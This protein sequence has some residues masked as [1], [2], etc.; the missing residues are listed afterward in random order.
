MERSEVA[1]LFALLRTA[2]FGGTLTTE[3]RAAYSP[4]RIS[5]LVPLAEAHDV[6]HL[7]ALGL[8]RA[9]FAESRE[10]EGEIFRAVLRCETQSH[11]L[12]TI[13][14]A[15]E[16]AHI[17]FVPLKGA[18]LRRHYP[19][20]WMRTSCDIDVLVHE[21]ELS[22]AIEQLEARGYRCEGRNY[23][24]VDLYAPSGVHV[25]LHF[26]IRENTPSLDGV[27]DDAWRYA[28]PVTEGGARCEF[29][30]EFF[31][32]HLYAHMAYHFLGGG[33]GLRSLLDILVL[34]REM[35]L[36]RADAAELLERAG[37]SRFASELS[38]LAARCFDPAEHEFFSDAVLQYIL[39]GGAYGSGENHIAVCKSERDSTALYA[40]KRLFLPYRSMTRLYPVLEKAPVLLPFCYV[41]RW[42]GAVVGGK[43]EKIAS[44][45]S[46]VRAMPTAKVDEVRSLRARLGL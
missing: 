33:C 4:E 6:V 35:G 29:S 20:P 16:E 8:K 43:R 32:F 12:D 13:S 40:I 38:A 42:V 37:I 23:H 5:R 17:A 26:S 41:A 11:A 7:L 15:L 3:E 28:A 24:D 46:C 21:E 27:L 45:L 22:A 14:A 10:L 9:G 44:E 25:E 2:V 34:E 31:V 36:S 19:E 39:S 30:G 18:I 1:L